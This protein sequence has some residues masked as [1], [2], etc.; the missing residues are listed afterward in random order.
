MTD[1]EGYVRFPTRE[2]LDRI[3]RKIDVIYEKLDAKAS[4]VDVQE[5]ALN[6]SKTISRVSALELMNTH[7]SAT[8]EKRRTTRERV[9]NVALGIALVLVTLAGVLGVHI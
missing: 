4:V 1:D 8:D 9:W 3:E 5:L 2:L 7:E 6:L